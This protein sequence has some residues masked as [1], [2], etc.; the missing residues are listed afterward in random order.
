MLTLDD[1]RKMVWDLFPYGLAWARKQG[2][3]D[4]LV[5]GIAS[6][7]ENA[8]GRKEQLLLEMDPRTADEMFGDWETECGL[9]DECSPVDI[10]VARR[11]G[12]LISKITSIGDM[13]PAYYLSIAE[14]L[15][16]DA[17]IFE[18]HP[19]TCGLS[20]CGSNDMLG[21]ENI[22]HAW[23][24]VLYGTRQ[25][26]FECG[27]NICTDPLGRWTDVNELECR[28]KRAK[29]AQTYVF[30]NYKEARA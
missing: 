15:G 12:A 22:R 5:T 2:A 13:R 7:L 30:F 19:V 18:W 23:D 20:E 28:V 11:R 14:D 27:I 16:Y 9:P 10:T 24:M 21:N 25:D 8:E 29:P 6:E 1:Y 3:L 17:D 4:G 26:Y